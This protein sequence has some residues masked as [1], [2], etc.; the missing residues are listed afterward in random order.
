M[1]V[2]D[3]G[4]RRGVGLLVPA[5][6]DLRAVRGPHLVRVRLHQGKAGGVGRE[7]GGQP[8]HRGRAPGAQRPPVVACG[9]GSG[10]TLLGEGL[11]HRGELRVEGE[12]HGRLRSRTAGWLPQLSSKA[13]ELRSRAGTEARLRPRK[14]SMAAVRGGRG[15]T[16]VARREP[17]GRAPLPLGVPAPDPRLSQPAPSPR[18]LPYSTEPEDAGARAPVPRPERVRPG[19]RAVAF[20]GLVDQSR[21]APL[22]SWRHFTSVVVSYVQSSIFFASG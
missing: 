5:D 1:G 10:A 16:P 6:E 8:P 22:G 4:A 14:P 12:G 3:R 21:W 13:A 11:Q 2:D 17:P 7:Q 15:K 9:R 19:H 20:A 18:P